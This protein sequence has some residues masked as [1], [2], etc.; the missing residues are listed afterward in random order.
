MTNWT[1]FSVALAFLSAGR[2]GSGIAPRWTRPVA[3]SLAHFLPY[4]F[5]LLWSERFP[6]LVHETTRPRWAQW[7]TTTGEAAKQ[8]LCQDKNPECLPIGDGIHS[9]HLNHHAVPQQVNRQR[10]KRDEAKYDYRKQEAK[11]STM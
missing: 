6:T 1:A 11:S 5:T 8:Y 2:F 7:P 4:S 3:K 10:E 9:E